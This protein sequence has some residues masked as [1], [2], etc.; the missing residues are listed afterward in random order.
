MNLQQKLWGSYCDMQ[1]FL[2]PTPP[3]LHSLVQLLRNDKILQ[4]SYDVF[5]QDSFKWKPNFTINLGLRYAWN[6]C[7][8]IRCHF[9]QFD[10]TAGILI[11]GEPALSHEQQELPAPRR[12]RLGSLSRMA[13]L[14]AGCLRHSDPGPLLRTSWSV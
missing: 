4:P 2:T 11:P 3:L 6:S 9:T 5:A 10:P 7:F 8:G 14:G 12:L 13:S 1:N